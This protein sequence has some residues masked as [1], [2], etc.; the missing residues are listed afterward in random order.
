[1]NLSGG[2]GPASL[3]VTY[4][5]NFTLGVAT[6]NGYTFNGWTYLGNPFTS[7]KWE[8]DSDITIIATYTPINYS[9]TYNDLEGAGHTNPLSYD[10][11]TA[12]ITLTD[13]AARTGYTFTGWFDDSNQEVEEIVL[14][15]TGNLILYAKWAVIDY[16]I[17][18]EN[19]NGTTTDN[20]ATYNITTATITLNN[21]TART[22]Y[23]FVGWYDALVD[24]NQVTQ[25]VLGSH[26]NKTLYARWS[27]TEFTITYNNL[28]DLDH[29][30]PE[31]YTLDTATITLVN[32]DPRDH[33]TFAGWFDALVDGNQVSTIVKGSHGNKVLYARWT[34]VQYSITYENLFDMVNSNTETYNIED[35]FQLVDPTIRT[36]YRFV[37]WFDDADSGN[38]VLE[39]TPGT[40]GNKTLYA[41]W[42]IAYYDIS[43]TFVYMAY[44]I[45]NDQTEIEETI[46][47]EGSQA[48][49]I[50]Q[51]LH[52][53][54]ISP[55]TAQEGYTF[56]KFEYL[57]NTYTDIEELITVVNDIILEDLTVYYMRII[58][59]IA[60]IQKDP[61]HI[62]PIDEYITEIRYVYYNGSLDPNNI[63]K[64]HN[65][66]QDITALWERSVFNNIKVT[67]DVS[68]LYFSSASKT[69][70][71]KDGSSIIFITSLGTQDSDTIF[72]TDESILW[73]LNR[74]GYKF[75]GWYYMDGEQEIKLNQYNIIGFDND[76]NEIYG[77]DYDYFVGN[78]IEIYTKWELLPVYG[79]PQNIDVVVEND[80][81]IITWELDLGSLAVPEFLFVID[82]V[83]V[84]NYETAVIRNGL[85]YT[86]TINSGSADHALFAS[87]TDVGLHSI[88]VQA[89]GDNQ[90]SVTGLA[91]D[92]F[93]FEM[94]SIY[95][96]PPEAVDVY[97]Y[98][99]IEEYQESS[100]YIFYTN[101]TYQFNASYTFEI[102]TGSALVTAVD[103]HIIQMNNIS[104]EFRFKLTKPDQSFEIY[105]ALVIKDVKQFVF[106]SNYQT[107]L[108]ETDSETS[109]YK[110]ID[111][112]YYVGTGN[113]YYLD[114]RMTN[115][116]GNRIPIDNVYLDYEVYL[117]SGGGYEVIQDISAHLTFKPNNR[118]EFKPA[119]NGNTYKIVIK[120]KYQSTNMVVNPLTYEFTVNNGV[121]VFTHQEL[122]QA[123]EDDEV[124]MIN[125]H[126]NI[127]PILSASQLN[128]DGSPKNVKNGAG[129]VY[130]RNFEA[131]QQDNLVIQGN[132]MTI[133]GSQ[134][135]YSNARS[136]S[137][138]VGFAEAF[139]IINVQIA[140]FN[141]SVNDNENNWISN[142]TMN[143]L[144]IIGNT[145]VP[146]VNFGGTAEEILL[147]ERLMSRNS[148]GY[149]GVMVSRGSSTFNNV[150]VKFSVIGFS[151][152]AHGEDLE[153]TLNH[154]IVDDSWAN[155]VYM[156]GATETTLTNSYFGQ[157]GGPAFHVS[158]SRQ[159]AGINNPIFN[160]IDTEIENYI[161]GE[162]AWFK[163]YGMSAVA[164][165]LKSAIETGIAPAGRSIIKLVT[166]P[167]T[168]VQTEMINLILLTEPHSGAKEVVGEDQVVGGSEVVINVGGTILARPYNYLSLG[169]PRVNEG[170]FAFPVGLYSDIG[171][172][173]Q[174]AL[175]DIGT[176]YHTL[177]G[178][179]PSEQVVNQLAQL[180][181]FY[182]LTAAQ[183]V[184][185]AVTAQQAEVDIGVKIME[186]IINNGITIPQYFEVLSPLP[187]FPDGYAV[188][189]IELQ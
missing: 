140:I 54:T 40:Y 31:T 124:Q 42:E 184:L 83:V 105:D 21:P 112:P 92:E 43:G 104:G 159:G 163:A 94:K 161:S 69:I 100:R 85:E 71:F 7:G 97:N 75:L 57:G 118:I 3:S 58:L 1:Y 10:I 18:Y 182:N 70:R 180:A 152:Y 130:N 20:P 15:S 99:I 30:N 158:D 174:L 157:S 166:H 38:R 139:E 16:D 137:S 165:Q 47:T 111:A 64:L 143:N 13:P 116:L 24:G 90:D 44:D 6:K 144:S 168:G 28:F 9:I 66:D 148:G 138:I 172:F 183:V 175:T 84:N 23:D 149:I 35:S 185:A 77:Y 50:P 60:F 119:A 181:A 121:N 187:V 101:M 80:N 45:S 62:P 125:L 73:S 41:R 136:G 110:L 114:V 135:P 65:E 128:P 93:I 55:V 108:R 25:I 5:E 151:N 153:M 14:G 150:Q 48:F 39:F 134:L 188:V 169:D 115:T 32:P 36:G 53:T 8:I 147:Q 173:S 103:N 102:L 19:L 177:T 81:V 127:A 129:N 120:P 141:Y 89:L 96:T 131:Q 117:N 34:P 22:G 78:Q 189:I 88:Q 29:N 49:F 76:D 164:L 176:E 107:Y 52:G 82:K 4:D 91:S 113:D 61:D 95:D 109:S 162:E 72:I 51:I 145:T 46:S 126:A 133:N 146:S 68:A 87:L 79:Q 12:T 154:V 123:F 156:Q 186:I 142:W 56:S 27:L 59:E 170:Q 122:K 86:L 33:Y 160:I 178:Q 2:S 106:G 37:G 63:P 26:G 67:T 179:V 17:N 171:A 167:I 98:F 132:Y 74:A 11:E 155:S